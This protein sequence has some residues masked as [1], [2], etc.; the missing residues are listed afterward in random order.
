MGASQETAERVWQEAGLAARISPREVDWNFLDDSLM[1]AMNTDLQL[2][3][4]E[5]AHS[6]LIALV[7]RGIVDVNHPKLKAALQATREE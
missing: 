1:A 3:R 4:L 2:A 7:K 6:L 5:G